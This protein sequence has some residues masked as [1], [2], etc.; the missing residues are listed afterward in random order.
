[1]SATL[2][3]LFTGKRITRLLKHTNLLLRLDKHFSILLQRLLHA[4]IPTLR[5][6]T[7]L[8]HLDLHLLPQERF[9]EARIQPDVIVSLY[10]SHPQRRRDELLYRIPAPST[11]S[12]RLRD[13]VLAFLDL[14]NM[15]RHR[16]V[17]AY[18][19]RIHQADQL[20][21]GEI[22]GRSGFAVRDI[23]FRRLKD[24]MQDEIR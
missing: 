1:M 16:R 7:N 3:K 17:G 14:G 18:T 11:A 12:S 8:P 21:L 6:R 9:P 15:L 13:H 19:I 23:R 4:I 22:P 10:Q 5:P 2:P 20:R 24:F